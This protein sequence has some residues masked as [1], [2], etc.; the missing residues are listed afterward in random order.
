M[1]PSLFPLPQSTYKN[2]HKKRV[3]L[4][5]ILT[6][7]IAQICKGVIA[8]MHLWNFKICKGI[9]GGQC[10]SL[11]YAKIRGKDNKLFLQ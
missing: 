7:I 5:L 9:G 11:T 3:S 1:K 10:A 4:F 8:S 2:N 6:V